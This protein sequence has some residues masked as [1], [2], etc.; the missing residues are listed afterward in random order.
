ML[1]KLLPINVVIDIIDNYIQL[2]KKLDIALIT[3]ELEIYLY[4]QTFILKCAISK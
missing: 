3:L 1:Q 4:F 2:W